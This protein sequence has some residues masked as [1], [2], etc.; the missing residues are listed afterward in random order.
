M[1]GISLKTLLITSL[2]SFSALAK[3]NITKL[4]Y[5]DDNNFGVVTINLKGALKDTPEL[6]IKG[7]I[8]QVAI[9]N[10]VVWP[11]IEKQVSVNKSFDTTLM[12][13]QYNK[14]LSRVR[15]NLP[16]KLDGK[17]SKVSVV[18]NDNNIQLFFPKQ[19][20][21]TKKIVTSVN[22]KTVESNK[23]KRVVKAKA[24]SYDESY[25][26]KLLKDKEQTK[27]QPVK[28]IA[29]TE[30]SL[31]EEMNTKKE[32]VSDAVGTKMSSFK[33]SEFNFTSY[34]FKFVGFFALLVA[35]I[36]FVMNFF[37][38]GMLKKGGLGFLSGT[39]MVEVLS[40]T[41]I[42]PKRSIL[43]LRVHKQVF[44]VAQSEKG[45]DFLTEIKDTAGFMKEGE[46]KVVGDNFD[47]NLDSAE[48]KGKEFKLKEVVSQLDNE[49]DSHDDV[50]P[51]L[52][53]LAGQTESQ[54]L[55]KVSLS[56]QIK[57][58]IKELKPLQ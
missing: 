29:K 20:S 16:Y 41:Y 23:P 19:K 55:N 33:K 5:K 34:I 48:E 15:A 24:S 50:D 44:L 30:T 8:V 47:T 32:V 31:F 7:N 1:K 37:R 9:P 39:K 4:S 21:L 51:V 10:S 35:G 18:L 26:E 46:R 40:T 58:K 52:A 25:L 28:K 11:K 36:Y 2:I 49:S 38:K 3:V 57:N 56:K 42:G 43:V 27:N 14:S 13:Y 45:M 53:A 22:K 17:E 12:A 6:Q 54:E